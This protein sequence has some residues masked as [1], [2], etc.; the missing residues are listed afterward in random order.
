[1]KNKPSSV[2]D[3]DETIALLPLSGALLLPQ[4]QR[5]LVIFEKR[6]LSLISDILSTDRIVGLI[7]PVDSSIESPA[8][9][10]SQLQKVG[11]LGYLRA[12]E[13]QEDDKFL[14]VLEGLCRFNLIEELSAEKPYRQA[15]VSYQ[16]Y[17]ADFDPDFGAEQV[18]R[19]EFL[20]SMRQ[21]ADFARFKFDWDGIK[22]LNTSML[23]NMCCV[24]SPY[25]A[26]EKQA[27]LEADSINH[28]AQTLIALAEMEIGAASGDNIQ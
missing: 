28:R 3:I 24:L 7:Q 27:L 14:V 9:R 16:D 23:I 22:L 4:T 8:S 1:M 10:H 17:K 6:Y 11:C 26:N 12:F 2:E 15:R 19:E 13:E 21:Y 5:P 20:R 18:N 25:G